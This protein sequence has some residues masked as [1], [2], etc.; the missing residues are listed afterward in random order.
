M[1]GFLKKILG[2]EPSLQGGG[3]KARSPR[4]RIPVID[5]VVFLTPDGKSHPIRNLSETGLAL[6]AE[7]E[8]F[9][10]EVAGEILAGGERVKAK[11][12]VVRRN[13]NELG[14]HFSEDP[15]EVRGLLRRIFSDELK[16]HGMT[17]VDPERQKALEAGKPRWFYAPGNYELFYAELDGKI[18]RFELEWNGNLIVYRQDTGLRYGQIDRSAN[19]EHDKVKH[20]QSSLVKWADAVKDSDRKKAA[21]LMENIEGLEPSA[22][23]ALQALL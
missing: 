23:A 16:A 1:K 2:K 3:R 14:A 21:R 15:V 18:I 7:N 13:G 20:A 19:Q 22:R 17:E 11:L 8:S 6:T 5:Q 10:D 9:P 12:K 4:V